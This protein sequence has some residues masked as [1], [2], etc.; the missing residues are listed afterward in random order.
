MRS[1]AFVF[2]FTFLLAASAEA[3]QWRVFGRSAAF[4]AHVSETG[5]PDPQSADFSTNWL[6]AGAE[7]SF[8]SG[9]ILFRARVTAEQA[10]IPDEG[11][12]QLFQQTGTL[13]DRMRAHESLEEAAVQLHW[14]A[15]RLYAAPKGEPPLGAVPYR[16]RA[17]SIDFVEAPFS[18]EVQESFHVAKKVGVLALETS[19][20][21]LE[22]GVF[23]LG[24]NSWAGRAILRP[25]P[26]L[27]LQAS[28]GVIGDAEEKI[29][30]AS[31]GYEGAVLAASAI[32]TSRDPDAA[33]GAEVALRSA[34][35][36]AMARAEHARE[37]V[38]VTVGYIFD[39]F[40]RGGYRAG[41]GANADYHT[42]THG[43]ERQY[44]HKPQ[45][46]Y[47]FARFRKE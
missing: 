36:V 14:R 17:S 26:H 46:I 25:M 47:V 35:N 15:L 19:A 2:L 40:S 45:S 32:W 38:H 8:G 34:H 43:L 29:T 11:Y 5:P 30:S 3:Q 37:R 21:T 31:I 6:I 42:K 9:S 28:H 18:Y 16:Q 39:L 27:A 22:G 4:L 7:R 12:P 41:I 10:T 20:L 23:D 33:Y 44:G 24:G 1:R 13:V